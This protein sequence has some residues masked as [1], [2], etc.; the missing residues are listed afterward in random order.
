MW[1]RCFPPTRVVSGC[2]L[3]VK[4]CQ[5]LRSVKVRG[6]GCNT[7]PP[8]LFQCAKP[9]IL[10]NQFFARGSCRVTKSL[11]EEPALGKSAVA[12]VMLQM[13]KIQRE[14][15]EIIYKVTVHTF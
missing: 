3:L 9:C 12:I 13:I 4:V 5:R 14:K 6:L 2:P 8:L 1:G 15:K 7:S 11:A 10:M